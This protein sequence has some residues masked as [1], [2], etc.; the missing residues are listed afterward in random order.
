MPVDTR[1]KRASS[2]QF[3]RPYLT[4]IPVPNGTI[5]Q[6]DRHHIIWDYGFVLSEITTLSAIFGQFHPVSVGRKIE[7]VGY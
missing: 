7:V 3:L 1:P 6:G 4:A 2:V 5:D